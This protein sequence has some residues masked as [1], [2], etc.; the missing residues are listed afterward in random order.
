MTRGRDLANWA[1]Q[2]EEWKWVEE[3]S[4]PRTQVSLFLFPILFP[5]TS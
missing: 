3:E 2:D 4:E 5:I 1:T